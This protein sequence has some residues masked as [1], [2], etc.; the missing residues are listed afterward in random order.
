MWDVTAALGAGEPK[1]PKKHRLENIFSF[2]VSGLAR[3]LIMGDYRL[4]MREW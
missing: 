2:V 3:F 1:W 4:E